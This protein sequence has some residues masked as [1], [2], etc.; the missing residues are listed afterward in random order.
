MQLY[1]LHLNEGELVKLL[2]LVDFYHA[3]CN[4]DDTACE[5][6]LKAMDK[7]GS[8]V[9]APAMYNEEIEYL[10]GPEESAR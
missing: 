8:M 5:L 9:A 6:W 4:Y 3:R 2:E 1:T 7:I 10:Y